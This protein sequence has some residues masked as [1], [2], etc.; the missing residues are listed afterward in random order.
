MVACF[1][2]DQCDLQKQCCLHLVKREAHHSI[3]MEQKRRWLELKSKGLKRELVGQ[4]K[5]ENDVHE[6][7]DNGSG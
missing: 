1:A 7:I 3:A 5:N 4:I 6:V 2:R